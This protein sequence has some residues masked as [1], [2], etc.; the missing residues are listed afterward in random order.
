M[1]GSD[2][3]ELNTLAFSGKRVNQSKAGGFVN[4]VA[5]VKIWLICQNLISSFMIKLELVHKFLM[6][7]ISK[8]EH[9][10]PVI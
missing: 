7:V 4:Q 2:L 1:G 8:G 9:F 5:S 10:P 3:T 6:S